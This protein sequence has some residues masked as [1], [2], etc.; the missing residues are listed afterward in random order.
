MILSYLPEGDRI[1]ELHLLC[2]HNRC[3]IEARVKSVDT[4]IRQRTNIVV[5]TIGAV[6]KSGF[7]KEFPDA[8]EGLSILVI[9]EGTRVSK[10]QADML[11]ISLKLP[12]FEVGALHC[13]M[14]IPEFLRH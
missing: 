5:A 9:D 11:L 4:E 6:I 1:A 3:V 2:A 7:E 13:K 8:E 10:Y 12:A 14:E